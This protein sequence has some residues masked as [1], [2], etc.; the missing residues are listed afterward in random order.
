[1]SPKPLFPTHLIS[2]NRAAFFNIRLTPAT[3]LAI[4][5]LSVR[6]IKDHSNSTLHKLAKVLIINSRFY[7]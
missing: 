4:S 1:M 7:S 5:V 2:Q 3:G 6:F